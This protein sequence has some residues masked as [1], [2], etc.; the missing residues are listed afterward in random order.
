MAT[1]TEAQQPPTGLPVETVSPEA[2]EALA[3][4][5]VQLAKQ[6]WPDK[7]TPQEQGALAR[8]HELYGLD[9]LLKE[10]IVLGGNLYTTRAGITRCAKR[11]PAKAPVSVQIIPATKEEREAAGCV[12]NDPTKPQYQHLWKCLLLK[13]GTPGEHPFI[14]FGMA[15]REDVNLSGKNFKTIRDMADTRAYNRTHRAAGYGPDLTSIEE[16]HIA[17]EQAEW[18]DATPI[19][20]A[21]RKRLW[22]LCHT[23]GLEADKLKEFLA[24][25]YN[26]E[27]TQEILCRDYDTI[28]LWIMEWKNVPKEKPEK[29]VQAELV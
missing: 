18:K 9:P 4:K 14:G 1:K 28:C 20:E 2:R 3:Q 24:A 26:I 5:N 23:V 11:D 10:I 25:T 12:Q 15:S 8:I 17:P 19:N 6:L 21:Q 22:G 7:L 29:P 16:M 13:P 27:S